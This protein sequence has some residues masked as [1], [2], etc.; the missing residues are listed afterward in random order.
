MIRV[1]AVGVVVADLILVRRDPVTTCVDQ[2]R[3]LPLLAAALSLRD[4]VGRSMPSRFIR[5]PASHSEDRRSVTGSFPIAL[6]RVANSKT[7]CNF[8]LVC[9]YHP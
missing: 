9:A 1:V 2:H 7:F 8:S 5:G 6:M 3:L 4:Q